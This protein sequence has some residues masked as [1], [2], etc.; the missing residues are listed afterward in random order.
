MSMPLRKILGSN[1]PKSITLQLFP[2]LQKVARWLM[3]RSSCSSTITNPQLQHLQ[4]LHNTLQIWCKSYILPTWQP[5]HIT[6]LPSLVRF[7]IVLLC[8][9]TLLTVGSFIVASLTTC[10]A[11]LS[12]YPMLENYLNHFKCTPLTL[13]LPLWNTLGHL[14]LVTK[15]NQCPPN[16]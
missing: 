13:R 15:S 5:W 7:L 2:H 3:T 1:K 4:N 8:K 9:N 11:P 10:M 6:I 12:N 16:S 14:E